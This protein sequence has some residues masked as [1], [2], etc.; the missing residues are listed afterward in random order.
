MQTKSAFTAAL[1][2]SIVIVT[3]LL[4]LVVYAYY[5]WDI[6]DLTTMIPLTFITLGVFFL[7]IGLSGRAFK[8]N[9]S[10]D[11]LT[12]IGIVTLVAV[13]FYLGT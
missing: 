4:V 10:Y 9:P 13:F 2:G 5:A 11:V 6:L 1:V 3:I 7:G 12:I 8:K